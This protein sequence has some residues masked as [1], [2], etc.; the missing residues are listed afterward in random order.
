LEL[1]HLLLTFVESI[2][3]DLF[4]HPADLFGRKLNVSQFFQGG[5]GLWKTTKVRSCPDDLLQDD[6]R[7]RLTNR[8]LKLPREREKNPGDKTG[9]GIAVRSTRSRSVCLAESRVPSL[10]RLHNNVHMSDKRTVPGPT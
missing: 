6:R 9:S 7:D 2:L 3:S 4:G 10:A 5:T 8:T 1:R